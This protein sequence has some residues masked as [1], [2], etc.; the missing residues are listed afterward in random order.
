[1]Y[2]FGS[3]PFGNSCSDLIKK[4]GPDPNRYAVGQKSILTVLKLFKKVFKKYFKTIVKVFENIK[5]ILK[6]LI[7]IEKVLKSI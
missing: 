7:S 1:M 3:E 5:S 4:R 6:V 2:K